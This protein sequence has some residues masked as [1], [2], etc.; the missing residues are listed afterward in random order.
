MSELLLN[1][2]LC[3]F[4][5]NTQIQDKLFCSECVSFTLVFLSSYGPRGIVYTHDPFV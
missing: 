3:C 1:L 2:H 5:H 4:P